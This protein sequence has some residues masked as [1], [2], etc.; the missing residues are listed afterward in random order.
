MQSPNRSNDRSAFLGMSKHMFTIIMAES[1]I[2]ELVDANTFGK[3]EFKIIPTA[4]IM[5]CS[6]GG[7][8][9]MQLRKFLIKFSGNGIIL[10]NK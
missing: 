9:T 10:V 2:D 3:L 1:M 7:S 8:I 6:T 4:M 5:L